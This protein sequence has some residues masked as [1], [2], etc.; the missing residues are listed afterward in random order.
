VLL[1]GLPSLAALVILAFAPKDDLARTLPIEDGFYALSVS[2]NV[3]TGDG[4][5]IGGV[6]T[7]GFQPLWT[8]L[9]V[10]L[11]WLA[12]G[13]RYAGLRLSQWLGTLLWAAFVVLVALLARRLARRHGLQGDL[14]AVLAAVVAA[15]SV[16]VLRI[17]HN[18]LETG[19]LLV[20]LAAT[21][22][23]LDDDRPWTARRIA[24]VGGLL[25]LL[26]WTR[27]DAALFAVALAAVA[28]WRQPRV[29]AACALAALAI[30]PWLAWNLHVDGSI[31]PTSGSAQ[32][33]AP[34][35]WRNADAALRA[36]G[37]WSLPAVFRPSLHER[38]VPL[39]ELVALAGVLL[40]A[41]AWW[42]LPRRRAA[43]AGPG[44]RALALYLIGLLAW[45]TLA[46]ESWWFLDRY[47]APV[48][49]VTLPWL[50]A[51]GERW[52]RPRAA[53]AIAAIV[54][55]ANVPLL[56]VL[57][58]APDTPPAWASRASNLGTHLN[59]NYAPQFTWTRANVRPGCPMAAFE[60]GTLGHFRENAA[61]LD[62][63]VNPEALDFRRRH[64]SHEYVERIGARVIVDIPSGVDRAVGPNTAQWREVRRLG[65]FRVAVRRDSEA[66]LASASAAGTAAAADGG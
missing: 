38:S 22:L 7:N 15:G 32:T 65:R 1:A 25:G 12:G 63:K 59:L 66:C 41:A 58:A 23:V 50:A 52:L 60:S 18:G 56:A 4:I 53:Y 20:V 42:S 43:R 55:L 44:T 46:F 28:A 57:V 62:G 34:D 64:R 24:V 33:G 51:A 61:N 49:L 48:V 37:A 16:S 45:Y 36:L 6:D 35:P 5:T 3:A 14:A 10:P 47:L 19:L 39:S 2:H 27:I 17:H 30:A 13:D 54:L 8:A 26:V 21:V 31:I 11:Y 29:L 9:N 40:V